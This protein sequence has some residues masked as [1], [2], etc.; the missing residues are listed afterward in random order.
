VHAA[1]PN[2]STAISKK[3][4]NFLFTKN[5]PFVFFLFFFLNLS[6]FYLPSPPLD[7]YIGLTEQE[8]NPDKYWV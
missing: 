5:P 7:I 1:N 2:V 6:N 8:Q 3:A 4:S